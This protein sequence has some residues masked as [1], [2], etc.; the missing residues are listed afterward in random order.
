[1]KNKFVKNQ[2]SLL[3]QSIKADRKLLFIM[4]YDFGFL[5]IIFMLS[6]ILGMI[7]QSFYSKIENLDISNLALMT[8]EQMKQPTEM[9][10]GFLLNVFILTTLF[11][12]IVYLL[13]AVSR[14]LIWVLILNK[15]F[16]HKDCGKFILTN[17]IWCVFFVIVVLLNR[18]VVQQFVYVFYFAIIPIFLY[19]TPILQIE[20]VLKNNIIKAFKEMF[21][22]GIKKIHLMIVP[23][24]IILKVF[25]LVCLLGWILL[26]SLKALANIPLMILL[27]LFL[28]WARIYLAEVVKGN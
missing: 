16:S 25:I 13:W 15:K 6:F 11:A 10:Q 12:I 20:F 17:M 28:A 1:M 7:F 23:L 3:K 24:L 4:L 22:A 5:A 2:L 27:F 8:A 21:G 26:I 18:Y 9:M 19:L 14:Y